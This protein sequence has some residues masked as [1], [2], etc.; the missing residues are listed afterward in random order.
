MS[1]KSKVTTQKRETRKEFR[2]LSK[3]RVHSQTELRSQEL[4]CVTNYSSVITP[5]E[6][7]GDSSYFFKQMKAKYLAERK[8]GDQRESVNYIKR[9]IESL[10]K[11][12]GD[13]G[14]KKILKCNH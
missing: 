2:I 5:K 13:P 12:K 8:K 6:G 11:Q 9:N 10:K 1:G 3:K 7:R 4:E 14:K